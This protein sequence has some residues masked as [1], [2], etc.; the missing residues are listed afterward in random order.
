MGVFYLWVYLR[1][2]SAEQDGIFHA[3]LEAEVA[4]Q[5]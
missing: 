4:A 3:K 2:M 1:R 5:I